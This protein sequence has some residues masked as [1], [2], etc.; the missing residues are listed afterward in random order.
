MSGKARDEFAAFIPDGDMAAFAATLPELLKKDFTGAMKLLREPVFQ[1]L[2]VDYPRPERTFLKAYEVEDEVSSVW[3]VRDVDGNEYKPE[4]YLAA[5]NRYVKEHEN[6]IEAIRILLKRPAKWSMEA[7]AELRRKLAASTLRFNEETLQ[8]AHA[9][10]YHKAMVDIISMVK[11]AA[12]AEEGLYTAEER[13]QRAMMRIT[14][15][16]KFTPEQMEWLERIR[17]HLVQNLSIGKDDFD[18]IP[19]FSHHGGWG[20]ANK[21][22]D[23]H[24][25]ELL[26]KVNEA[27]AV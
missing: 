3:I 5:F 11:H 10:T 4:D 7:L 25:Q 19:V 22:F 26:K 9:L 17:I 6:E 2:L 12:R 8:K 21:S 18:D 1:K 15:R 27:I 20:R 13:V 24:L 14:G 16:Q 23:G